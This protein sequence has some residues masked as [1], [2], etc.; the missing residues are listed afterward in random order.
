MLDTATRIAA[1]IVPRWA[2]RALGAVNRVRYRGTARRC[3]VCESELRAFLPLP[4]AFRV[5]LDVRGSPFTFRDFETQSVDD[6]LCPVCRSADRD[7]L[8]A[9]FLDGKIRR[10]E[11]GGTLLHFAPE[12]ALA[13]RLRA[14]PWAHRTADLFMSGVDERL[15]ITRM[16]RRG[17]GS[18]DCFVCSHV[19]EHVEDDR[20]AMRE[21]FRIL[22]PGGW[23]VVLAPILRG[24]AATHEGATTSPAERRRRFGQDDHLRVYAGADLV[25]RLEGAGFRV[26][27]L[28]VDAF[29]PD[30]FRR[31]GID[32]GSRL[33]V[34]AK[35]A[36]R[37]APAAGRAP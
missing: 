20:Q 14:S 16:D 7:R 36:A 34:V 28:G 24:L 37:A 35:A 6:Y 5:A 13:R 25:A 4:R 11:A 30:A 9:L 3:P 23:G 32:P 1:R 8:I 19:L 18:V 21:L 26:E 17:D 29:G 2:L 22:A 33:Y 31:A 27:A 15:D 12:P 10:G